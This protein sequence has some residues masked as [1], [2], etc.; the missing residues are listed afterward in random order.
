MASADDA[1]RQNVLSLD[2]GLDPFID[3]TMFI[4]E[5]MENPF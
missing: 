5:F 2:D 4:K 1:P 3:K